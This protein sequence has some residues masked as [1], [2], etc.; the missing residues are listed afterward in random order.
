MYLNLMRDQLLQPN[1]LLFST[2]GL[3][4]T[5]IQVRHGTKCPNVPSYPDAYP[6]ALME[7]FRFIH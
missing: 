2:S 7:L 6:D 5:L 1:S 3:C 4:C